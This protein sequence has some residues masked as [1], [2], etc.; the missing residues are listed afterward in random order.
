MNENKTIGE[1]WEGILN[2]LSTDEKEVLY[3]VIGKAH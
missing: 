2:K 3:F 1:I